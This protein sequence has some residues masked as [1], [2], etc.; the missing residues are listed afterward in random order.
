MES[1]SSGNLVVI[2]PDRQDKATLATLAR[3]VLAVL[4]KTT[5]NKP[6]LVHPNTGAVCLLIEGETS[7]IS[8]ALE[9]NCGSEVRWLLAQIAGS[10]ATY[11]LNAAHGWSQQHCR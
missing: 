11:G 5:G 8:K 3:T 9:Q 7:K 10:L 1:R 4:E 6:Q 2:F